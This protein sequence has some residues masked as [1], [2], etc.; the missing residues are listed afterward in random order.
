MTL[1][2]GATGGALE[3]ALDRNMTYSAHA[4]RDASVA[5]VRRQVRKTPRWPRSRANF[6]PL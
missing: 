3:L 6:S 5:F 2:P 1:P 4:L